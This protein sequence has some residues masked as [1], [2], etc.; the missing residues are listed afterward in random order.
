MKPRSSFKGRTNNKLTMMSRL[1]LKTISTRKTIISRKKQMMLIL[2][3]RSKEAR[4]K[5]M[6]RS[7]S[8]INSKRWKRKKG[9]SNKIMAQ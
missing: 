6:T 5:R 4:M 8:I 3:A 2:R 7:T 1:S 9:L